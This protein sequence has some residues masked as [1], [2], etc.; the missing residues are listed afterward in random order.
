MVYLVCCKEGDLMLEVIMC[1]IEYVKK[2]DV[3]VVLIL[4]IKFVI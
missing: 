1:V 4:G 2:Y 3:F